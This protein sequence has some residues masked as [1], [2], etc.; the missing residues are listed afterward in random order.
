M[1]GKVYAQVYS[2]IRVERE[3]LIEALK[4]FSRVGYDGVEIVSD[5]TG[6]LSLEDFQKLLE[7]LKLKV[8]AI[9]GWGSDDEINMAHALGIHYL[10]FDAKFEDKKRETILKV[11]RELNEKGQQIRNLGMFLTIHNHADEFLW[12][13]GEEGKT[14]VYD[15]LLSETDPDLVGFQLD[16]GWAALAGADVVEYVKQNPGRFPLIHVKECD[17]VAKDPVEFEH[18]PPEIV[19]QIRRDE[20]GAPIFTD[21]IK[22]QLYETRNWNRALGHGIIDWKALAEAAIAQG[23]EAF[24]S[25]R[26]YYHVEGSDGTA[27]RC[28]ELDYEYLRAL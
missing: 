18:F 25:E 8:I 9:H 6:G 20:H 27:L 15:L 28:V 13:E 19:K 22:A 26:E 7:E 14:R 10:A 11:C 21:D 2:L 4:E 24:I 3:G 17:H 5:N 1:E 16:T 23:C 12:V